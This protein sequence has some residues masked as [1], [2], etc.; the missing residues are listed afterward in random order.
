[1]QVSGDN[2]QVS[3]LKVISIADIKQSN[4]TILENGTDTG[5]WYEYHKIISFLKTFSVKILKSSQ[6]ELK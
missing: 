5:D 4:N 6:S 3:R 2:M 1:M